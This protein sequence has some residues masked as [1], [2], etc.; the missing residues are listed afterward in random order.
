MI[1]S[2]FNPM[3]DLQAQDRAHRI[4]QT[5]EVHVFRLV[6]NTPIESRILARASD[7]MDLNVRPPGGGAR[8]AG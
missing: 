2:D 3:M 5:R 4:G 1:D 8:G 6:T 7:K